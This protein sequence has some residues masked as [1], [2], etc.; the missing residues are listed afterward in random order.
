[1]PLAPHPRIFFW[2]IGMVR[3]TRMRILIEG[4]E[5]EEEGGMVKSTSA[6]SYF[7]QKSRI[8]TQKS[9]IYTQK[10]PIHTQKSATCT[11]ERQL[12]EVRAHHHDL[13]P[14]HCI[15]RC[16]ERE[17]YMINKRGR[18]AKVCKGGDRCRVTCKTTEGKSCQHLH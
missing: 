17:G 6:P 4:T 7:A 3:S 16:I 14:L 9:L 18:T 1:V 11:Q 5:E 2:K 8:C 15:Y 12:S 10:S 13:L